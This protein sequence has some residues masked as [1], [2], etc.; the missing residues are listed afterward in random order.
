MIA[1]A[2]YTPSLEQIDAVLDFLPTFEREDFVPSKVEAPPGQFP[3]H[4]FAEELS[5]FHQV[6][7]D[8]GFV[9]SF[10]W[11]SWQEEAQRYYEQPELLRTADLQVLRKLI[12]LHVRKERFC[13]G[14]LPAMVKCGHI[15]AILRRLK[16][17]REASHCSH[18]GKPA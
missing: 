14:H 3:Y 6:L 17:L 12:T 4:V 8:N 5:Q 16:E 13:E 10:D 11:P 9:L 15:T 18:E 1:D 7:Y 2:H